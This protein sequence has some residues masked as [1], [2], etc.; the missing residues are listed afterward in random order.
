MLDSHIRQESSFLP[1][2]SN[3]GSVRDSFGSPHLKRLSFVVWCTGKKKTPSDE[4]V[5]EQPG[6]DK[7]SRTD[8]ARHVAEEYANDQRGVLKTYR[9]TLH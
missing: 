4:P 5:D 2:G 8:E 1:I 3:G 9:K 6:A 7:P